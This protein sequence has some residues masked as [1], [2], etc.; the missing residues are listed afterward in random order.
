[1]K[2]YRLGFSDWEYSVNET[3]YNE[4]KEYSD[5]EFRTLCAD[6]TC[7]EIYNHWLQNEEFIKEELKA[8]P[9]EQN[10]ELLY[11][12]ELNEIRFEDVHSEVLEKLKLKGFQVLIED[13]SFIMSSCE[14]ILGAEHNDEETVLVKE[15]YKLFQRKQK[16]ERLTK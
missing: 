6:I 7:E 10:I 13:V 3:L 16:L 12:K 9:E 14:G 2:F 1:M 15:R 4:T 11:G 8:R 5:A